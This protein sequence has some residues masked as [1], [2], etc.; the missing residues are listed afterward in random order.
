MKAKTLLFIALLMTTAMYGF[1]QNT[2]QSRGS[3]PLKMQALKQHKNSLEQTIFLNKA[4][5][6]EE[7]TMTVDTSWYSFSTPQDS[8]GEIQKRMV[9]QWDNNGNLIIFESYYWSSTLN[10]WRGIVRNEYTYDAN[11]NQ[12]LFIRF[13]N[14]ESNEWVYFDKHEYIFDNNGFQT[15][16]IKH[17]WNTTSNSWEF[18]EKNEFTY[19][20]NGD[21]SLNM[22]YE[23]NST[24]G[25]WENYSKMEYYYDTNL[26]LI[27]TYSYYWN[28]NVN[29]WE[30][31]L[32]D[33]F[34]YDTSNNLIKEIFSFGSDSLWYLVY[35]YEYAYDDNNNQTSKS[36][37]EWDLMYNFWWGM[38]K[39]EFSFDANNVLA[40]KIM[41]YAE[42]LTEDWEVYSKNVFGYNANNNLTSD[43]FYLFDYNTTNDWEI[44]AKNEYRY[45]VDNN[46]TVDSYYDWDN[47]IN[48]WVLQ[49]R[50][51]Y[52]INNTILTIAENNTDT[53]LIYPNPVRNTLNLNGLPDNAKVSIYNTEG[54]LLL[55][56]I[57]RSF[58]VGQLTKGTYVV[59]ILSTNNISSYKF[60]K[61]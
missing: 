24:T 32:K 61:N 58:S 57:E 44:S 4:L 48:T 18:T 45:D 23:W 16:D 37:S 21:L 36:K 12:T 14:N 43:I 1:G 55:E 9:K 29:D 27:L 41:S 17:Q 46:Q 10:N 59:R 52:N 3:E 51:Y 60:I 39:Y 56:G 47:D 40:T 20:L 15:Q 22:Y 42:Y 26:N 50:C 53:I 6:L 30:K 31:D 33:E 8:T 34:T 13:G 28:S 49:N 7:T 5:N 19:N 11:N 25:D 35:K 2:M 54:K 38:Y